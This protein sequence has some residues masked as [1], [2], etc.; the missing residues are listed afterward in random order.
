M[1]MGLSLLWLIFYFSSPKKTAVYSLPPHSRKIPGHP[2]VNYRRCM[3]EF[4][5]FCDIVILIKV[6]LP[7]PVGL[8]GPVIEV[9]ILS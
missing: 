1:G 9:L 5:R 8:D 2:P 4:D 3:L 6:V 7:E